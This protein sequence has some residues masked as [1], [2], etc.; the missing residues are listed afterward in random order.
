[1][2]LQVSLGQNNTLA[3]CPA[4][5]SHS[6]KSE[7][8]LKYAGITPTTTRI[9]VG[10][11]DPRIFLSHLQRAAEMALDPVINGFSQGFPSGPEIDN[12]FIETSKETQARHLA[13]L[14]TYETLM[15]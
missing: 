10:L 9:A 8:A 4:I 13:S 2:G 7:Q 5:T 6:E 11:E 15:S 14:P 3:L 12:I 1:M